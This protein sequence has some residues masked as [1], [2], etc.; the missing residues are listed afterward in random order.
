MPT[1]TE[2]PAIASTCS[3]DSFKGQLSPLLVSLV[4]DGLAVTIG[5]LI[6]D[7][8]SLRPVQSVK[9]HSESLS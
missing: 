7:T 8:E 4:Q 6:H 2:P 5:E 3:S 9:D 1:A